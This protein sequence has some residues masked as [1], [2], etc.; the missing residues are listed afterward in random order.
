[1]NT[2][3]RGIQRNIY[4]SLSKQLNFSTIKTS[5]AKHLRLIFH[6]KI[7]SVPKII[8]KTKDVYIYV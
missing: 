3:I 2:Y 5:I 4:I 1:M 6:F 7:K 8:I